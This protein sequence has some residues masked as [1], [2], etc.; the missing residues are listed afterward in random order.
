MIQFIK[1]IASSFF[2]ISVAFAGPVGT[3]K[4]LEGKAFLLREGKFTPVYEGDYLEDLD[5]ISTEEGA[6]MIVS[7]YF[8]RLYHLSGSSNI[9][10]Y[11]SMVELRSGVVWMQS[12]RT[13]KKTYLKTSNSQV[14]F[15]YGEAIISLDP[16]TQK[17]QVLV[18]GGEFYLSNLQSISREVMIRGGRFSF[19]DNKYQKGIPR[20]PTII[21]KGSYD[22][23]LSLFP[24]VVPLSGS[25]TLA[26]DHSEGK[27][28][29]RI[30]ASEAYKIDTELTSLHHTILKKTLPKRA[31]KKSFVKSK[32]IV[33]VRSYIVK[34]KKR[35]KSKLKR[36]IASKKESIKYGSLFHKDLVQEYKTQKR[37][38]DELNKLIKEL[39]NYKDDFTTQY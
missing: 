26:V 6:L 4:K 34:M 32:K 20:T 24:K 9:K 39:K 8:D 27:K 2:L 17:T 19:V 33:P 14:S 35:K 1:I 10:F 12:R 5:E 13:T 29:S 23:A 11:N 36:S 21:G 18:L 3:V 16:Y 15:S 37:H 28:R 30:L 25:R 7:D 38:S 31:K 22:K